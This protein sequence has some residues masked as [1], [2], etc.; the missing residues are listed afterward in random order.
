MSKEIPFKKPDALASLPPCPV[1]T[2]S[3]CGK[4]VDEVGMVTPGWGCLGCIPAAAIQDVCSLLNDRQNMR[5]ALEL[6]LEWVDKSDN[7]D[8]A[9]GHVR[10]FVERALAELSTPTCRVSLLR[11]R[12]GP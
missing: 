4:H 2:C 6:C 8:D 11:L 1:M 5:T 7:V 3:R 12:L 9:R 10:H